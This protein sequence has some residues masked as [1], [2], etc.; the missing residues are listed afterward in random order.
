M[1]ADARVVNMGCEAVGGGD[2]FTGTRI[3][4]VGRRAVDGD[5]APDTV[6]TSSASTGSPTSPVTCPSILT[7]FAL[8][9]KSPESLSSLVCAGVEPHECCVVLGKSVRLD[10]T[11]AS[12]ERTSQIVGKSGLREVTESL[13]FNGIRVVSDSD[14]DGVGLNFE[15]DAQPSSPTM[16]ST[17]D[18]I[19][20][21]RSYCTLSGRHCDSNG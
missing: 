20:C 18:G 8:A 15:D 11:K 5:I 9:F 16:G 21:E 6:V 2:I 17:F 7:T 14:G 12:S 13:R 4:N 1:F 10:C 3:V 19:I